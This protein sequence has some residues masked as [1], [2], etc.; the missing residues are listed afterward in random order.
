MGRAMTSEADTDPPPPAAA[1][2]G[3]GRPRRPATETQQQRVERLQTELQHAQEALK[4]A[5][6]KRAGIVGAA[7]IHHSRS[8]AQFRRQLAA[9]LRAEVKSKADLAAV[10]D[11]LVE[12]P[13]TVDS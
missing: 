6:E 10:A 2:R 7:A 3:P 9:M 13:V 4:L 8:H 1:K 12:S 5:E 11:L